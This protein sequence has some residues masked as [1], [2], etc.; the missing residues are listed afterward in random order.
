LPGTDQIPAEV[1]QAGGKTLLSAD[2]NSWIQFEIRKACL[3][4]EMSEL[5]YQFTKR[6]IKLNLI[7]IMGYNCYQL[8]AILYQVSF[9]Q[10]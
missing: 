8:H 10:S 2:T 5:L 3:I 9:S 7:I 6:A 1:I 4:R